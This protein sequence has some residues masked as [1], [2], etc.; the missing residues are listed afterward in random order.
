MFKNFFRNDKSMNRDMI[1]ARAHQAEIRNELF[2]P[3][4]FMG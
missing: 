2:F 1:E 3:A 4:S